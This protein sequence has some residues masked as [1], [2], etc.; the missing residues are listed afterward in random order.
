MGLFGNES[1]RQAKRLPVEHW[2]LW[3]Y[4]IRVESDEAAAAAVSAQ[5]TGASALEIAKELH[6]TC[7]AGASREA[8]KYYPQQ[9]VELAFAN[10]D[11]QRKAV[12]RLDRCQINQTA[13]PPFTSDVIEGVQRAVEA[14]F[15]P[16]KRRESEIADL[17]TRYAHV[18]ATPV[19]LLAEAQELSA[20]EA[21]LGRRGAAPDPELNARVKRDLGVEDT[22]FNT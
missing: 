9:S 21:E 15:D 2:M 10:L 16:E 4:T 5:L 17:Q 14:Y 11:I 22:P 7:W 20:I 18:N 12:A 3:S 6:G 1:R 19:P 8:V 13:M